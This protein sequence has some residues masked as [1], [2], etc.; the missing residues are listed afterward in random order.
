MIRPKREVLSTIKA[1]QRTQNG[2]QFTVYECYLGV[3]ANG[4]KIRISR[5]TRE[6]LIDKVNAY[7]KDM[8]TMGDARVVLKPAQIYDAKQA[9]DILKDNFYNITLTDCVRAWVARRREEAK[10][11]QTPIGK[12]YR[13]YYESIPVQQAMHRKSVIARVQK[14]VFA[15]GGE[16][17]VSEVT[18]EEFKKYLEKFKNDTT[19]NNVLTYCK[20]FLNWCCAKSRLYIGRNPLE[21]LKPRRIMYE[22]PEFASVQDVRRIFNELVKRND[23]EAI[24]YTALSFFCGIRFAEI[25]RI[26]ESEDGNHAID[27]ADGTVRIEMPK[28]WTQGMA[29]RVFRMEDNALQ[30]MRY[31]GRDALKRFSAFN[32]RTRMHQVA[33]E[34]KIKFPHN[35]G[36]H[37][38]ITY[39]VAK[40]ELPER[41]EAI[42]G[43]SKAMRARHYQGLVKKT[44]ADEYFSIV[45]E[46]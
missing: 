11:L 32:A 24:I 6:E 16:R 15:F 34:I 2:N 5:N 26:G 10:I 12:A 39:H 3:D 41:T 19:Y 22:T 38:F 4:R 7:Y 9:L 23:I 44:E 29:P 46:A 43:T 20:T 27:I 45:P 18:E 8:R 21:D 40:Y 13:E 36:R 31:C 17:A 25:E 37:S 1:R 28:G 42:A 35:A 33:E 14:W 30:W